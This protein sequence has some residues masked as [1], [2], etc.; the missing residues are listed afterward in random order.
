MNPQRFGGYDA[1]TGRKL[2]RLCGDS[3]PRTPHRECTTISFQTKLAYE[4]ALLRFERSP[5]S[6]A[7]KP[8]AD[9]AAPF[10][11]PRTVRLARLSA[12]G[13]S[14]AILKPPA[15]SGPKARGAPGWR[16][17]G[18]C[19]AWRRAPPGEPFPQPPAWTCAA[20]S[21]GWHDQSAKTFTPLGCGVPE[22]TSD[23]EEEQRGPPG[24]G[25]PVASVWEG[26]WIY[27]FES[28]AAAAAAAG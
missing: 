25:E 21:W 19:L 8:A 3:L 12:D 28:D 14:F 10:A 24:K 6:G 15:S 1:V 7:V 4:T 9:L 27:A 5:S 23:G 22:Y 20:A 26:K 18:L 16:R 17:C 2:W 13:A 11:A